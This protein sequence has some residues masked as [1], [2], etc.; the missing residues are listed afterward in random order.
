MPIAAVPEIIPSQETRD[1]E[2]KQK[3]LERKLNDPTTSE[4]TKQKLVRDA[5]SSQI[6]SEAV[7]NSKLASHVNPDSLFE[8]MNKEDGF[9]ISQADDGSLRC[10][11]QGKPCYA[12]TLVHRFSDL[13]PNLFD[14]SY[15]SLSK[16][17]YRS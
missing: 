2:A 10:E 12:S 8:L 7:K 17:L 15:S 5:R 13:H 6:V 14:E 11:Y 16:R 3:E 4:L 9:S 1:A